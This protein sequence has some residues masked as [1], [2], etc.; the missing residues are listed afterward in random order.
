MELS[1]Q[2]AT[3]NQS[4]TDRIKAVITL[5]KERLMQVLTDETKNIRC[6]KVIARGMWEELGKHL[7]SD[8]HRL[9]CISLTF[10]VDEMEINVFISFTVGHSHDDDCD[11]IWSAKGRS[12]QGWGVCI[13]YE[14]ETELDA[15]MAHLKVES[16]DEDF[17]TF[18]KLLKFLYE[19]RKD[20]GFDR[21]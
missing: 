11:A 6:I 15:D 17:P 10:V 1:W 8:F 9:S 5:R 19:H 20:I 16:S 18:A 12:Y 4:I 2:I 7:N 21:S 14:E 3:L 13:F